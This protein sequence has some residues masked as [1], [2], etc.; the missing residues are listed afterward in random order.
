MAVAREWIQPRWRLEISNDETTVR[1][2]FDESGRGAVV[3]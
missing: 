2:D 1:L 3:Q